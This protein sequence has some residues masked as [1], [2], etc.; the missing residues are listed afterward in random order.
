MNEQIQA[1]VDI[2]YSLA[3]ATRIAAS[4][5]AFVPSG[6]LSTYLPTAEQL[7][8]GVSGADAER[9]RGQWYATAPDEFARLLDATEQD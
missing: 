3:D 6:E 1:L 7:E 8:Q 9:A 5:A 4:A 2:G